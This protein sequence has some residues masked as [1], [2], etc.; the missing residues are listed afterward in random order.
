M[1]K[2]IKKVKTT[3]SNLWSADLETED[4]RTIC[5]LSFSAK[6][7]EVVKDEKG[8][9]VI[10]EIIVHQLSRRVPLNQKDMKTIFYDKHGA[11]MLCFKNNKLKFDNNLPKLNDFKGNYKKAL[12]MLANF[13]DEQL[14]EFVKLNYR[15]DGT[16]I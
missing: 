8:F 3:I 9:F 2:K 4:K 16:G 14:L 1:K 15:N 7:Y 13:T 12:R 6:L 11:E 10:D 5:E